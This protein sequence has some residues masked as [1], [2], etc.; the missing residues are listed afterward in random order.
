MNIEHKIKS[1]LLAAIIGDALGVPVENNSEQELSLCSVKNI[2]GYGRYDQPQGT[3]SDDSAMI[4]CTIESLC[5]GYDIEKLGQI[6]C[7]WL[8]EA[9]WTASGV[10]FD[11]GIATV[12]ALDHIKTEGWSAFES[13]SKLEHDNGNG[14]LMRI[15][16][17]A[18]YL[19]NLPSDVFLKRIH[20]V[21]AIT[22]A[23]PRSLVG[24]GLYALL[25]RELLKTNDKETALRAAVSEA[26]L[27]YNNFTDLKKE[28]S[29]YMRI[30]SF[31]ILRAEKNE[32]KASGY[33]IDTLES[34]IWCF[35]KNNSTP[36]ILLS[37]IGLGLDTDT[38]GTIAGGLAGLIYGLEDVPGHWTMTLARKQEIENLINN[39]ASVILNNI[40]LP[41]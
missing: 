12:I 31:E 9:Y 29:S 17:A 30:L 33:I 15:L 37:A 18:L 13:G 32:I 26:L 24:C 39:F 21:S 2:F 35:I 16:P 3:W 7:K 27:F 38:T 19:H 36:E 40:N 1:S 34:A 28:L 10:V 6:F 11:A 23:H 25:V 8:F 14:S 5:N 20:E 4:L 41:N 22:H